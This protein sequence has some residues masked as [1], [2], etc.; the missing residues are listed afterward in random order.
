MTQLTSG[1]SRIQTQS[2]CL[3]FPATFLIINYQWPKEF[4]KKRE[5][6]EDL[7]VFIEGFMEVGRD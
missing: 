7:L 1:R 4:L 2:Q 3:E 6:S 5:I